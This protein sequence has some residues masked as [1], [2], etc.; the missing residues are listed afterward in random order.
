MRAVL[1]RLPHQDADDRV[2]TALF[3]WTYGSSVLA[4]AAF[5]G[6]PAVALVG[7]IGMGLVSLPFARS[8]ARSLRRG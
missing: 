6:R 1:D 7:G 5:F 3:L 2:P 8:A 4:N